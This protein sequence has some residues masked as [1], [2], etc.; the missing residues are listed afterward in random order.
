MP[1]REPARSEIVSAAESLEEELAALEAAS[2][3]ASKARLDSEKSISRATKELQEA[4]TVPER[5][6]QGLSTLGAAMERMQVRQQA[7]L[8]ELARH[9]TTIQE[10]VRKLEEHMRAYAALGQAAS[11][12]TA[13]L[14][15]E[16][17]RALIVESAKTRL[18]M[19]VDDARTLHDAA[20]ADDFPEIAREADA[21]R[22]SM[23][24]LRRRFESSN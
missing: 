4:L 10:R 18:S 7:A 15:S 5:L 3:A 14:Q 22:Q 21:L 9:A 17:D 19:I 13:L 16:G 1:S 8:E 12:A 11:E 23:S 2:R 20:R 24:A 6:A